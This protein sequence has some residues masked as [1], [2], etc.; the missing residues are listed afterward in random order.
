MP[1]KVLRD[2]LVA[3]GQI[4]RY[5]EGST[6]VNL[7]RGL[8]TR[9]SSGIFDLIE[10]PIVL[11]NGQPRPADVTLMV[12]DGEDWVSVETFPRGLST[13]DQPGV[14]SVRNW[15]YYCLP[16]GTMLPEGLCIV[17]DQWNQRYRA[18]H[19]TIAPAYDMP[20][21]RFRELLNRLALSLVQ[22]LA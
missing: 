22:R 9:R 15:A 5:F 2:I 10:H 18:T 7:W 21:A 3:A 14:P 1:A 6:P 17:R 20:L 12:V 13:F 16:A 4:D 19:Y 8:H 11:S